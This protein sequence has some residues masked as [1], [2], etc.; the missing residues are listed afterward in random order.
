MLDVPQP[1]VDEQGIEGQILRVDR[2]GN[3][4][5]NIDRK[6]FDKLAGTPLDIRVGDHQ[7][8]KVV[9][10]YAD[11]A[12]GEVCGL[13]GST[14]HLEIAANG[15]SAAARLDLGRGALV[16]VTRRA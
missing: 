15:D 11:G 3:L 8:Q 16:H 1:T 14:E 9:S 4:I 13:F 12:S 5:S 6:T 7:V 2:F 10:T